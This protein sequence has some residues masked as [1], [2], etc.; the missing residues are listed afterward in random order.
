MFQPSERRIRRDSAIDNH[1]SRLSTCL[2]CCGLA[3]PFLTTIILIACRFFF[4]RLLSTEAPTSPKL[5]EEGVESA[6]L[7]NSTAIIPTVL[8]RGS[9]SV[10]NSQ[11]PRSWTLLDSKANFGR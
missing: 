10:R 7:T 2:G 8:S 6:L 11:T 3:C 9:L 1:N 5:G 4:A